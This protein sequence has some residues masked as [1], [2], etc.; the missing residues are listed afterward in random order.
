MDP[1]DD[2]QA[3]PLSDIPPHIQRIEPA[4]P[5]ESSTALRKAKNEKVPLGQ[6]GTYK[7]IVRR[8]LSSLRHFSVVIGPDGDL[9]DGWEELSDKKQ[10]MYCAA[11]LAELHDLTYRELED[12]LEANKLFALETGFDP[13]EI[14][15]QSTFSRH[16]R[17]FDGDII[18]EAASAADN[19]AL[20]DILQG[21]TTF[22]SLPPTPGKPHQYYENVAEQREVSMSA[23]M[24]QASRVVAEY[25]D[26][27]A[28]HIGFGRNPS[29]PNL[30]YPTESFYRLLAHIAIENCHLKNG[31]EIFKWKSDDDVA[32][33]PPDTL[34][35]YIKKMG[36]V[37]EIEEQ[38][39]KATCALLERESLGLPDGKIHLA[40][41]ITQQAWYGSEH[42]W[43]TGS[44]KKDNTTQFWHYAVL[45]T[46]GGDRNYILGATPIKNKSD[47]SAALDRLLGNVREHLD[48]DI[49]RIYMDRGMYQTDFVRR[50]H[51]H[52]LNWMIQAPKTGRPKEVAMEAGPGKPN[53]DKGIDFGKATFS[54]KINVFAYPLNEEE[55]GYEE[56]V[57]ELEQTEITKPEQGATTGKDSPPESEMGT[58]LGDFISGGTI[59]E[60]ESVEKIDGSAEGHTV[61]IT[62]LNVD[63]RDLQGLNYQFRDRWQVETAI[64]QLKHTFTGR[65]GSSKERVRAHHFGT[66]TLFFN[67]WVALKHELPY[68]LGAPDNLRLTGLELLHAIRDADFEA[69][70]TGDSR[71]I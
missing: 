43:T 8:T 16:I 70:K 65:C 22:Q 64:R 15:D 14:P 21:R 25:M 36:H 34:R 31:Y 38:F 57:K 12:V 42:G 54:E 61:W 37:K 29:S 68:H 63:E 55:V 50:C 58:S 17:E 46:V 40:Y 27:V 33:P 23:K 20:Y 2:E 19:A 62:N 32:I 45:S 52:G 1:T 4:R 24:D 10:R 13:G 35:R 7:P 51:D 53:K 18:Q 60:P 11:V 6:F 39:L 28:P 69:A 67:F 47:A 5:P 71:L 44:K 48:F 59:P 41:D 3:G 49:G 66:A 26:L 9:I 56:R 30:K